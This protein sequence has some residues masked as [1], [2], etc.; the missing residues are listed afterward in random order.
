MTI[1]TVTYEK[2]SI[3]PFTR[4]LYI[5]KNLELRIMIDNSCEDIGKYYECR[6]EYNGHTNFIIEESMREM[7]IKL[8]EKIDAL[9]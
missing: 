3:I 6:Y 4:I 9:P 8:R 1:K 2:S 7:F 5:S